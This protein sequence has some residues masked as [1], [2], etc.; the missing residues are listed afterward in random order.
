MTDTLRL[1]PNP[2]LQ[3]NFAPWR[4]ESDFQRLPVRG[5][6]PAELRG[7]YYRNGPNPAFDPIGRYHWF[8]GDGM[9]HAIRISE[10]G[11][12]YRNRWVRSIGLQEEI[13][14]GRALYYGLLDLDRAQGKYKNTANTNVLFH[15]SRLLALMEGGLPTELDPNTLAT[16]GEYDF[17]GKLGGPMTAHPKVDPVTGELLFFGY[18][19]I[20]PFLTFYRADARGQLFSIEPIAGGMPA[21]VHDFAI[22]ENYAVFFVCPLMFRLENLGSDRPVFSWEPE[23]GTRWGILPRGGSG[24]EIYWFDHEPCFIFHAMNAFERGRTVIV[25]VVRYPELR[26]LEPQQAEGKGH[27]FDK[28]RPALW[29]FTVELDTKRLFGEQLGPLMCEFP[30]ID[31]RFTGREYRLGFTVGEQDRARGG[32]AVPVFDSVAKWNLQTGKME[33]RDFGPHAG[34]GEPVFVPRSRSAKEGEGYVLTLVYDE[35]R[36]TS[37]LHVVSAENF[38]G[39]PVAVIELPHRVPYGFHGAWVPEK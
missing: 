8:D 14:A 39:E 32:A 25:D 23:Q 17:A 18:S 6:L 19:P 38:Q 28:H 9:V 20:P 13:R 16:L 24:D 33:I 21:M 29:R 3:G 37:E 35:N 1:A 15:A 22:T 27:N 5:R 12:S 7:T 30:R 10:E 2:F 11:V 26:F 34:V 31:E 4:E 36:D